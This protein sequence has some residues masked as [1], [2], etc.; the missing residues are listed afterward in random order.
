MTSIEASSVEE[1]IKANTKAAERKAD[2]PQTLEDAVSKLNVYGRMSLVCRIIGSQPWAKDLKNSQYSSIPVDDM[3]AGVREACA[4]AG[5]VHIGP[6]DMEVERVAIERTTRFYGSCKFRYINVDKPDEVIE[7]DSIGEAMDNGDK[8]TA[9]LVTNLIKNHYKA[10]FDIGE[11]GIDDIDHYSN[12]DLWTEADTIKANS[13]RIL[14]KATEKRTDS[15]LG[16]NKR[17]SQ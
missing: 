7:F 13:V 15:F 2:A 1:T 8:G 6:I 4:K 12:V 11:Q 10:A 3:R 9:K 5:L 16:E 17:V 14:G